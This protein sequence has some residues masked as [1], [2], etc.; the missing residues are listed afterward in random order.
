LVL[1]GIALTLLA[2]GDRETPEQRLERLRG[3][4][5]ITPLGYT[6]VHNP[7]TGEPSL[8]VDLQVVNQGTEQLDHLTVLVRVIPRDG[9]APITRRVT[10]DMSDV[11]PGVGV[12][13]SSSVPGLEVAEGD[14]VQVEIERNLTPEELRTLPE[15]QD[16]TKR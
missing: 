8:V 10:L 5:E 2:C 7:T 1:A 15:Y 9:S 6:T 3:R 11:R 12:Q 13:L 14:E 4:F 16:L